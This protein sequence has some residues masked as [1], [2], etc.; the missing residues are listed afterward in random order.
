M[1]LVAGAIADPVRREILELLRG[2]PRAAGAIA[3][4][5]AISRPAVSAATSA[6]CARPGLVVDDAR[7]PRA[8]LPARRRPAGRARRLAGAVPRRA[9]WAP[10]S[11]PSP[12]R[13]TA[14][15]ATAAAA[16]H[17]TPHRPHRGENRMTPP[18]PTG[19]LLATATGRDLVLTRT[20]RAPIDD[21][22]A[23]ITESERTA[24]WFASWTGEPGVGRTIRSRMVAEDGQP[25]A[26]MTIDACEP[27]RHLAVST[28]DE[29]GTWR[30]EATL[31]EQD[32]TTV[33]T[34]VHHLDAGAD[35][36]STGP[37]WEYYLDMLVAVARRRP[38]PDFDDYYPAQKAF[39]E[40]LG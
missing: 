33:L 34:F 10:A 11:T 7:G 27:P 1:N 8:R 36:A 26:D 25:E 28:V 24:R 32:G 3:E 35:V 39:Y 19:R 17:A 31:V 30:L 20:F 13:S 23:S 9:G 29:Y 37:G 2:G 38:A 6:S 15:G 22:W 16:Q 12:P 18:R 5:F 4:R 40:G 21:V 14:P